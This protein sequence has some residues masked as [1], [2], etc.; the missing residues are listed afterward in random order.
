MVP[1]STM[2][3][4]IMIS[5]AWY[6]KVRFLSRARTPGP[7]GRFPLVWGESQKSFVFAPKIY[8]KSLCE[9]SAQWCPK[10]C[11]RVPQRSPKD[12]TKSVK[13]SPRA[14]SKAMPEKAT[15]W[16]AYHLE[17]IAPVQAGLLFLPEPR[18]AERSQK[19]CPKESKSDTEP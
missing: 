6:Q 10:W 15:F 13:S 14:P 2:V 3:P 12:T 8:S 4:T 9:I 11:Q 5:E 19:R 1:K 17:N 7:A 16:S 18:T